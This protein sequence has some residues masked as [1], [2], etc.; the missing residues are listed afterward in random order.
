[1]HRTRIEGYVDPDTA[2]LIEQSDYSKSGFIREAVQ[3]KVE[4]EGLA[5]E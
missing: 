5:D 1:V 4:R 2:E 3:E